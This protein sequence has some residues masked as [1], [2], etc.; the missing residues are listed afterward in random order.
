MTLIA[1]VC[2][3]ACSDE[4]ARENFSSISSETDLSVPANG[5][6]ASP[7]SQ[8]SSS[9]DSS[10]ETDLSAPADGSSASPGSQQ[11]SS[12]NPNVSIY[13]SEY[14][15]GSGSNSY[16]ELYNPRDTAFPLSGW[17]LRQYNNGNAPTTLYT[18]NLA[19]NI[20]AYGVF[21]IRNNAATGWKG[22][23]DMSDSGNTMGFNGNDAMGLFNGNTRVDI[24]G[25][26][27]SSANIIQNMT[28]VRRPGKGP[29][30]VFSIDDWY[31]LASDTFTYL[32]AHDPVNGIEEPGTSSAGDLPISYPKGT[33][34]SDVY[35][36]EYFN[37]EN[38]DKYIEIYNNTDATVDLSAY[39]LL[40]I[41]A[42]N[43]SGAT[44]TANS[45]CVQLSGNLYAANVLVV[46]NA[47]YNQARLP[48]IP[49]LTTAAFGDSR[50]I[51]EPPTYPKGICHFG[52]NDPVYLIKDGLVIDAIGKTASTDI[53]GKDKVW[54]RNGGETHGNPIWDSDDWTGY[55]LEL[56]PGDSDTYAD[57][58]GYFGGWHDPTW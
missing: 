11:P 47:G 7:G 17:S 35:I 36:S 1:L 33:A 28:L 14:V 43:S 39:R 58:N 27:G 22:T 19:G 30:D 49:E 16:I 12:A 24:V 18:F 25:V 5:S 52:G 50:R 3:C 29:A 41:D 21:I 26:P 57:G 40:R 23:A 42:D 31:Q 10:T 53:W 13:I 54:V 34:G 4:A 55:D 51:D 44:N 32:G 56:E 9:A 20:P 8:Q 45:Y 2:L 48:V 46:I 38:N 37:G 6:S 15:E